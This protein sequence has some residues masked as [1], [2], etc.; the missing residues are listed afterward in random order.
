MQIPK[1]LI[2][3]EKDLLKKKNLT[4]KE[5]QILELL[6]KRKMLLVEMRNILHVILSSKPLRTLLN[7]E[8]TQNSL[9][10]QKLNSLERKRIKKEF[11]VPSKP[12]FKHFPS[13]VRE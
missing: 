10:K 2:L 13:S 6:K 4:L 8:I 7:E 11:N 3:L 1:K 12:E 9:E 5:K